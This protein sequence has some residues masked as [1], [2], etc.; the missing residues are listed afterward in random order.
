V[1]F[2]QR[3]EHGA[4]QQAALQPACGRLQRFDIVFDRFDLRQAQRQTLLEELACGIQQE[5]AQ[6]VERQLG[7]GR[8]GRRQ[9]A[10]RCDPRRQRR[11]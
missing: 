11:R 1:S 8:R 3:I 10:A 4:L 6:R 2:E 9:R 7:F 5:A